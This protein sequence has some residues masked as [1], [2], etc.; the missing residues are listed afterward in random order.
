MKREIYILGSR[1]Y[2]VRLFKLDKAY[3]NILNNL[4]PIYSVIMDFKR[5]KKSF[6]DAYRG[7]VFVYKHEQNFRVQIFFSILVFAAMFILGLAKGEKIVIAL[8]VLLVL[9]LEI[10]NSVI[11][12]F[13]DIIKPRMQMQVG[14]VKNIMASM[15]FLAVLFAFVIGLIIFTPYILAR[16]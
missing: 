12:K 11:E 2:G 4:M 8:L 9:I 13:L 7:M 3:L 10:L 15:V 5:L 6:K 1:K 16:F 14:I